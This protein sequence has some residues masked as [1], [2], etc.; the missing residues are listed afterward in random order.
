MAYNNTAAL[1]KLACTDYVAFGKCQDRLGRFSWTK[2]DSKYLD[3]KIKVFMR[4]DR[5]AEFRLKRNFTM[6]D[7]DSN[8]VIPQ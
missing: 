4:E 3:I 8:Q 2:N 6:G 1:D 5:N 7:A